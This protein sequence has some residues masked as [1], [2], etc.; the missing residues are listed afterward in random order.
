MIV[1]ARSIVNRVDESSNTKSD[2]IDT[3]SR[4]EGEEGKLVTTEI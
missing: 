4:V 1:V 2:S 3:D